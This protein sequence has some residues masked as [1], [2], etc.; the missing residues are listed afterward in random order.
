MKNC[1]NIMTRSQ[2]FIVKGGVFFKREIKFHL[3]LF[4]SERNDE[5]TWY[6]FLPSSLQKTY[7][8]PIRQL[9]WYTPIEPL[10]TTVF[11]LPEFQDVCTSSY[12]INAVL[13][14]LF[15]K[16]ISN[17]IKK[18]VLNQVHA[19]MHIL[20]LLVTLMFLWV[21]DCHLRRMIYMYNDL[22]TWA[23][24][25]KLVIPVIYINVHL[26]AMYNI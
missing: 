1:E 2:L 8:I 11:G 3:E 22:E 16:V 6:P 10:L 24:I 13:P 18:E 12:W 4:T 9:K 5:S 25:V 21:S 20:L 23:F 7:N 14:V 26:Y 19:C 17:A 15:K